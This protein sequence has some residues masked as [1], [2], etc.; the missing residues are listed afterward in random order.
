MYFENAAPFS[1]LKGHSLILLTFSQVLSLRIKETHSPFLFRETR[2]RWICTILWSIPLFPNSCCCFSHPHIQP[3]TPIR[4]YSSFRVIMLL[5]RSSCA[6]SSAKQPFYPFKFRN[7][8]LFRKLDARIISSFR[9]FRVGSIAFSKINDSRNRIIIFDSLL[10]I[11]RYKKKNIYNAI[12][13][14]CIAIK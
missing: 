10:N 8:E 1:F 11:F 9:R 13:N 2:F 12:N 3:P 14:E 5:F 4:R 6:L 7:M